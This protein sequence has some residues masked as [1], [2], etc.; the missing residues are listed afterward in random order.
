MTRRL[1]HKERFLRAINHEESDKIPTYGFKSEIGFDKKYLKKRMG[2]DVIPRKNKIKFGQD[3]TVLVALGVDAT[4]DP[5]LE[6]IFDTNEF[7][8]ETI[9]RSDRSFIL[10]SG[11][12][13][14][15]ASDGRLFYVGGAWTSLEVRN[16]QFPPRIP[17]PQRLFDR[18]E[19]F[20][21]QKVIRSSMGSMFHLDG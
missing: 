8:F 3:Q 4:T 16:E 20:Y 19:K 18:F 9:W 17:P 13:F 6:N 5:R 14:K 1:S 15:R 2:I 7:K 11:L 10:E 21:N 12:I